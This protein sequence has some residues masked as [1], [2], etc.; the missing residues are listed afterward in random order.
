MKFNFPSINKYIRES[1]IVITSNEMSKEYINIPQLMFSQ[2][3]SIVQIVKMRLPIIHKMIGCLWESKKSSSSIV[4]NSQGD[5]KTMTAKDLAELENFIKSLD[6]DDIG[7]AK[8]SPD[9][10]FKEH[11]ILYGNALV[12]V[13]EMRED[14]IKK[15]PSKA[16]LREVFRTYYKLGIIVNK[17]ADYLR[18]RGYNAMAGPAIGGD[19]N[20]VPLAEKA[21]LGCMGKHGLLIT[22]KFG[23]SLR[24]A[25]VYTDIENLPFFEEENQHL[26]IK[27]YCKTCTK[28][29]RRCLGNAIFHET[30]KGKAVDQTKCALPFSKEYGCSVCIKKCSFFDNSYQKIKEVFN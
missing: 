3:I 23:P 14:A 9:L 21:G 8:V 15:A 16:T 6:I 17:I 4:Q 29:E 7:Y 18:Q 27:E 19:V 13:M 1:D 10:V 26:W 2:K 25:T 28:C 30:I 12:L 11:K 5:K 22:E 20:Y 24:L